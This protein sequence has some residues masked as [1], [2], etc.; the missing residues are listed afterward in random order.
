MN[1][2]EIVQTLAEVERLMDLLRESAQGYQHQP[3]EK[4]PLFENEQDGTP[5]VRR[6]YTRSHIIF[7]PNSWGWTCGFCGL[8]E[9]E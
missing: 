1:K 5:W 4:C 6:H 8:E 9:E 3:G 2:E 7:G